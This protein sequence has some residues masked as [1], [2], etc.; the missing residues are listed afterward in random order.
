MERAVA[1]R[2]PYC[3]SDSYEVMYKG[4]SIPTVAHADITQFNLV[5]CRKC[6]T[7]F[8]NPAPDPDELLVYYP[9]DYYQA[10]SAGIPPILEKI[11]R[12]WS[13]VVRQ[14]RPLLLD[15]HHTETRRILEVGCA[16]GDNLKPFLEAG[17]AVSAIEPNPRLATLAAE[18]GIEVH[19]GS[20]DSAHWQSETF[21]VV[22]LNHVLE[23]V[24]NPRET[25]EK[26]AYWL[27]PQGML[28]LEVPVFAAPSASLF[29]RYWGDLEF[30]IHLTLL[31]RNNLLQLLRD[32]GS[33]IVKTKTRTLYGNILRALSHRFPVSRHAEGLPKIAFLLFALVVQSGFI[34]LNLCLGRGEAI[35]VV[36]M[37]GSGQR[38][39]SHTIARAR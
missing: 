28:Y 26:C 23:H 4:A 20:V 32:T 17:W 39:S 8:V 31:P 35:S 38:E 34:L 25:L 29:G 5:R 30:P 13:Y 33:V 11:N 22:L 14:M 2:C 18:K 6:Y 9:D 3:A 12:S 37:R 1:R 16:S 24:Y 21:D 27:R 36:A 15:D 19:V 7:I 10:G